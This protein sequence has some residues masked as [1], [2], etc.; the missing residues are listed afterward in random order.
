MFKDKK[1]AFYKKENDKLHSELRKLKDQNKSLI[2][3]NKELE[4]KL[5]DYKITILSFSNEHEERMSELESAIE[6]AKRQKENYKRLAKE[7]E[8][9]KNKYQKDMDKF[10]KATKITF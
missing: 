7:V 4:S 8:T 3:N 5:D 6:E 1:L 2:D 10:V 9:L